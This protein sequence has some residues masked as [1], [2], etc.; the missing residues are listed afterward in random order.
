M[1]KLAGIVR[2]Q[3][4]TILRAMPHLTALK[5]FVAPTPSI[6]EH[7]MWVVLTG[8]PPKDAPM[9]VVAPAVSAAKPWT[10]VSFVILAPIVFTMRQPPAI[11]PSAIDAWAISTTQNGTGSA[12]GSTLEPKYPMLNKS[13]VMMPIV[14]STMTEAVSTGRDK[15]E[16]L[17]PPID[18]GG[19]AFSNG[20]EHDDHE[21]E[22]DDQTDER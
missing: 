4:Q 19:F 12:F 13:G 9:I 5:R 15:L 16:L 20:T 11:V 18:L 3:A 10:G 2:I 7:M 17:E 22:P 6:V 1:N 14:F 21:E 8:I